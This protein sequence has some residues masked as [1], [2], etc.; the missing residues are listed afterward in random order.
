MPSPVVVAATLLVVALAA[1]CGTD[2]LRTDSMVDFPGFESHLV[3]LPNPAEMPTHA[4]EWERLCGADVRFCGEVQ[5]PESI[6]FDQQGHTRA[7]PTAGSSSGTASGAPRR[8]EG[9]AAGVSPSEHICNRPL[10]LCFDKTGD[11]YIADA[12]FGL[13][14]VRREAGL[15]TLLA[16]EAE[17]VRFNF[18]ND[19][20]LDLDDEGNIYFT[21]SSIHYQRRL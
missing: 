6:T 10:G 18:T 9:L 17:G 15:A 16:T 7:S 13:L 19:L 12:Y 4:D 11:L 5:G 20:D 8:A 1:F 21:D 3:D 2:P 14:K